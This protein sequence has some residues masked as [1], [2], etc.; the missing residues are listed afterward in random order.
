MKNI[1]ANILYDDN[2][3]PIQD[4]NRM[5]KEV[6]FIDRNIKQAKFTD[7][8]SMSEQSLK[9]EY[10]YMLK[11]KFDYLKKHPI[12]EEIHNLKN[13]Y[14]AGSI[15]TSFIRDDLERKEIN[16]ELDN[17]FYNFM[18]QISASDILSELDSFKIE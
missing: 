12:E 9:H 6:E 2:Y 13:D 18:A 10:K 5:I 16:N 3:N 11:V 17:N 14:K 15:Y 4:I 7:K 1:K 8:Y